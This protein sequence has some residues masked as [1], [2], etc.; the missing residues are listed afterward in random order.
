MFPKPDNPVPVCVTTCNPE[1][2]FG[3]TIP[4]WQDVKQDSQTQPKLDKLS[5]TQKGD[6]TTLLESFAD[7]FQDTPGTTTLCS[8]HINLIPGSKPVSSHP[9]RL[10]P[11]KA[12]S[13]EKEISELLN[14]GIIKHSDSPWASPTYCYGTQG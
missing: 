8:H 3:D 12:A 1:N 13:V 4:A 10:H 5:N 7:I 9:Y 6:V 14:L 11:E 2:D